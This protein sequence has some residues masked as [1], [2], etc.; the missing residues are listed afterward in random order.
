MRT[1]VMRKVLFFTPAIFGIVFYS[2]LAVFSGFGA[3]HLAVWLCIALLFA[4]AILI[5]KKK[6]FGCIPGILVGVILIWMSFQYTGQVIDIER[7]LDIVL[8]LF[9]I[10]SWLVSRKVQ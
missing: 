4:S 8:I 10:L 5:A 1:I 2:L 6:W 3:I 9:Y 7:P